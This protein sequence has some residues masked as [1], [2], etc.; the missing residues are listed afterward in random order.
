MKHNFKIGDKVILNMNHS[1]L[2]SIGYIKASFGYKATD[3]V[4]IVNDMLLYNNKVVTIYD[5]SST[6]I[7]IEEDPSKYH[8]YFALVFP[9]TEYGKYLYAE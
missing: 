5:K 8:F 6:S 3:G 2:I 9:A 1:Y 7:Q 4:D